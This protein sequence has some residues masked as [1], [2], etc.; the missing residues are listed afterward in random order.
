[1]EFSRK[2]VQEDLSITVE[3][4]RNGVSKMKNWKAAGPD[5]VQGFWFKKLTAL[6]SI[7][8]E[9]LQDCICQENVPEWMARGRT[10]LIQKDTAKDAQASNYR[11][12]ASQ[13]IMWKLLTGVMGENLPPL[14]QE[15]TANR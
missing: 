14:G 11:P 3:D 2:E 8:Q 9:C 1:M 15:W 5:L 12:F 4:N 7:L 13:P 6:H 10:V